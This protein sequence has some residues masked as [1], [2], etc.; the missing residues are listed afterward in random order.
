[1]L[2]QQRHAVP[3]GPDEPNFSLDLH[4]D[5]TVTVIEVDGELDAATAHLLTDLV[6]YV[7][8]HPTR[9]VVLDLYRLQFLS[10]AG[11][12]ALLHIRQ[13]VTDAGGELSIRGTCPVTR[14]VL[15]ITG[16]LEEFD[17]E[18]PP[19]RVPPRE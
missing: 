13:Q 8:T 10:A 3:V 18:A 2:T 17:L 7:P 5:G 1:M 19:S 6:Q 11:I 16:L 12:T 9:R 14:R 15:H 4:C